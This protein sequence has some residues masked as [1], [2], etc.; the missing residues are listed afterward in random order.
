VRGPSTT[1]MATGGAPPSPSSGAE[2]DDQ[3]PTPAGSA[4]DWPRR[5]RRRRVSPHQRTTA[6]SE[7]RTTRAGRSSISTAGTRP[8]HSLTSQWHVGQLPRR[9][10]APPAME[11]PGQGPRAGRWWRQRDS[12]SPSY[13][14][15]A[16]P[17]RLPPSSLSILRIKRL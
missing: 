16:L 3:C 2:S 4:R 12:S 6:T 9:V 1:T 11:Q 17:A 14:R 8:P 7:P 15:Q 13:P 5:R 10:M